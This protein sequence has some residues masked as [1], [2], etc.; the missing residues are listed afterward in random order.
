M[1]FN[2]LPFSLN[3]GTDSGFSFV[4]S[5]PVGSSDSPS[6]SVIDRQAGSHDQ[7]GTKQFTTKTYAVQLLPLSLSPGSPSVI[8]GMTFD[9][10]ISF[11]WV[12]GHT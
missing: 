2:Y 3:V 4:V 1:Q 5:L 11:W 7:A 6:F 9:P 12:K 10:S 8:L